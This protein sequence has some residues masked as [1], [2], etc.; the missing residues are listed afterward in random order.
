MALE[1]SESETGAEGRDSED[2][3]RVVIIITC[4]H[5]EYF[6]PQFSTE[7]ITYL[8]FNIRGSAVNTPLSVNA[9]SGMLLPSKSIYGILLFVTLNTD[10][11]CTHITFCS[12]SAA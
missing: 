1:T 10:Y 5:W 6:L 7:L 2:S 9:A 11:L 4:N 3:K 8:R 12:S